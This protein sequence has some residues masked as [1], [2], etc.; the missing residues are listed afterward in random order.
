M[1]STNQIAPASPVA[2]KL[3]NW[4]IK[5]QPKL[6]T[7][8]KGYATEMLFT[9][10]FDWALYAFVVEKCGLVDG[11]LIMTVATLVYCRFVLW[12]YD[13][14]K[15]DWW[16]FEEIK[17]AIDGVAGYHGGNVFRRIGVR[18]YGFMLSH[19]Y[20]LTALGVAL[21]SRGDSVTTVI[22]V[23]RQKF[24]GLGPREWFVF[25]TVII[26]GNAVWAPMIYLGLNVI[27][28]GF[29]G[30]LTTFGF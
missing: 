10:L 2:S 26:V 1:S 17:S 9:A 6:V 20:F 8:T 21:I 24:G 4:F 16:G 27:K 18:I 28:L 12:I 13:T 11:F 23:R 14:T 22:F 25:L 19:G 5:W 7:W 29:E 15:T 30:A 3:G